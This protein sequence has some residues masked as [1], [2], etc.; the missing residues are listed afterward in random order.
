MKKIYLLLFILFLGSCKK[1]WIQLPANNE[2]RP[3]SNSTSTNDYYLPDSLLVIPRQQNSFLLG[4]TSIYL[5]CTPYGSLPFGVVHEL[6]NKNPNKFDYLKIVVDGVWRAPEAIWFTNNFATPGFP[7]SYYNVSNPFFWAPTLD[8]VENVNKSKIEGGI[9]IEKRKLNDSIMNI[10]VKVQFFKDLNPN[11]YSVAVYV[12]ESGTYFHSRR[13]NIDRPTGA[14]TYDTVW[15]TYTQIYRGTASYTGL[16]SAN[17]TYT[18]SSPL[19][20]TIIEDSTVKAG[21]V[22]NLSFTWTRPF[23]VPNIRNPVINLDS[24]GVVAVLYQGS[25]N[26]PKPIR[27]LNSD[28]D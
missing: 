14:V 10:G 8:S 15:G 25:Q 9:Q 22:H 4:F 23:K 12:Y 19:L 28:S 1:D 18:Y 27:V 6:K 17:T 16:T 24:C 26:N 7:I 20:G 21:D 5:S 2:I 3:N 11:L 13:T